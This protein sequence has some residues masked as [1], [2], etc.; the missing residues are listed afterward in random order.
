MGQAHSKT[1][2]DWTVSEDELEGIELVCLNEKDFQI[3]HTDCVGSWP[4]YLS[5]A[6]PAVS[7][8]PSF[9]PSPLQLIGK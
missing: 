5:F 3:Q 2:A 6:V 7:T 8:A 1:N 9:A 4:L